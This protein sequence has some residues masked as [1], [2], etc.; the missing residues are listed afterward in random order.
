VVQAQLGV[1]AVAREAARAAAL[2]QD[3]GEA[4]ARG[5]SHG[6]AVAAGYLLSRDALQLSVEP[7]G[8][9]RGGQVRAVARYEVAL[10]DLPILQWARMSVSSDQVER[11]D[12]YRSRWP[13]PGER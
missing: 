13:S 12:L 8:F 4:R 5:I 1:S 2:A 7:G 9:G 3:A 11:L 6:Q 10:G